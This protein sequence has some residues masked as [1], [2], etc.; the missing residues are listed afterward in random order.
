MRAAEKELRDDED[1]HLGNPEHLLSTIQTS[2][3]GPGGKRRVPLCRE[4]RRRTPVLASRYMY[5]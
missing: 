5:S 2:G 1:G 3:V 4:V